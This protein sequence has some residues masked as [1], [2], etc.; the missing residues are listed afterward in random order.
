MANTI[1]ALG[2]TRWSMLITANTTASMFTTILGSSDDGAG[3]SSSA[4]SGSVTIPNIT[5]TMY[6]LVT[7]QHNGSSQAD[8]IQHRKTVLFKE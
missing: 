6:L 4:Y 2:S 5:S 8:V 1:Q 7:A 3:S